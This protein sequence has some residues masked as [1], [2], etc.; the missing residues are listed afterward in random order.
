[1][2]NFLGPLLGLG[3]KLI[4][5]LDLDDEKKNEAKLKLAAMEQQGKLKEYETQL[6]AILAEAKSADPWTSR[7]RPSFLYVM[8][9]FILAAIPFGLASLYDPGVVGTVAD[10]MA[11]WLGAIP[12]ELYALFGAGYLGYSGARSYDKGKILGG[13]RN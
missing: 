10:G 12:G 8:Y 11:A 6:S 13:K 2:I 9:V 4:D 5:S 3:T 7:A 1:M